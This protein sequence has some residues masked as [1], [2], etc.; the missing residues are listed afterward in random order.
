MVAVNHVEGHLLSNWA[1]NKEGLPKRNIEFPALCL[2]VSGGHTKLIMI[3]NKA[4]QVHR[5]FRNTI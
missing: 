3:S 5:M 4:N 1:Q 2:T